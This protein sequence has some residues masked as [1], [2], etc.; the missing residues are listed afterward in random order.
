MEL[1]DSILRG[2]NPS[3][4]D[5]AS[6]TTT[7][8]RVYV[9]TRRRVTRAPVKSVR[10]HPVDWIIQAVS[11]EVNIS[12]QKPNW[13]LCGKVTVRRGLLVSATISLTRSLA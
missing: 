1:V 3:A 13:I 4:W 2:I 7:W 8:S 12:S 9:W 11:I 5:T 6:G 10:I